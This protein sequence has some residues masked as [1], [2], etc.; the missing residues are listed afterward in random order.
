MPVY[1]AKAYHIWTDMINDLG[2]EC[3]TKAHRDFFEWLQD[4]D[5]E[6]PDFETGPKVFQVNGE[7][8]LFSSA[9]P[10]SDPYRL[11]LKA[12]EMGLEETDPTLYVRL[13]R[14]LGAI[15][16]AQEHYLYMA[17]QLNQPDDVIS[18]VYEARVVEAAKL[19][20]HEQRT[21]YA[22]IIINATTVPEQERARRKWHGTTTARNRARDAV[23]FMA[24]LRM[25]A[26]EDPHNLRSAQKLPASDTAAY[27]RTNA[28]WELGYLQKQ[29]EY[30]RDT[31][32]GPADH[33][34]L[35][36]DSPIVL[37]RLTDNYEFGVGEENIKYVL[38]HFDEELF[39]E[40]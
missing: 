40:S 9:G 16:D 7:R 36:L 20:I 1:V 15:Q 31:G 10:V 19:R 38:Q 34:E 12:Q 2:H 37:N 27:D 33:E 28:E 26:G 30:E 21:K 3:K 5:G 23:A 17:K 24:V 14:R 13:K 8:F 32:Q 29:Q 22:N 6:D 39:G 4:I 35:S 11:K 25:Y 18:Y